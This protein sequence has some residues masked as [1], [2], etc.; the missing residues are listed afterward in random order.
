MIARMSLTAYHEAGH[1]VAAVLLRRWLLKVSIR[2]KSGQIGLALCGRPPNLNPRRSSNRW[3]TH[4]MIEREIVIAFAGP[5]AESIARGQRR[6]RTAVADAATI[7]NLLSRITS[8]RAE[9]MARGGELGQAAIQLI[10]G[11]WPAVRRVA[12]ALAQSGELTGAAVRRLVRTRPLR[13][14]ASR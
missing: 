1:A 12:Q 6:F 7:E 5:V 10:R 2:R 3:R 4:R 9:L 13:Q 8:S 14:R 11:N